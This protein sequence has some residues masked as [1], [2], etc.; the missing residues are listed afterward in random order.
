MD[1]QVKRDK[2]GMLT[3]CLGGKRG[4]AGLLELSGESR[5]DDR[6]R[7]GEDLGRMRWRNVR[8][9]DLDERGSSTKSQEQRGCH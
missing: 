9:T 6:K 1:E 2:A 4:R 5:V 8:R 3:E 7:D